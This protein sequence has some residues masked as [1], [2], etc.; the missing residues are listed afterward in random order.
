M[1]H[2][3]KAFEKILGHTHTQAGGTWKEQNARYKSGK[4]EMRVIFMITYFG[5]AEQAEIVNEC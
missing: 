5:H 1:R 2:V 3:I 4:E